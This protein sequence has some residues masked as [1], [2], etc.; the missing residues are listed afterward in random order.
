MIDG[1]GHDGPTCIDGP[2]CPERALL[3]ARPAVCSEVGNAVWIVLRGGKRFMDCAQ[4]W[5]TLYGCVLR[6][7]K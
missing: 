6:G 7:A 4:G 2:M 1:A 3:R 5:E